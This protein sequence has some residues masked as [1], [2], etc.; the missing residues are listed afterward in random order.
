MSGK[1]HSPQILE[2]LKGFSTCTIANAIEYLNVRLRNVGFGDSS[3]H[4]RFPHF[5]PAVGYAVTLRLHGA[6][7]PMEG[8]FYVERTDWWDDL[9]ETPA[10][11]IVVIEDA[12]HRVGI[13]AF[14]GEIHAAILQAM[15][16][17]AVITNGSVR[18][19]EQVSALGFQLFSGNVS[20]SHAYAHVAKVDTPVRVAGLNIAP[21]D[22]LHGDQHGIVKIPR[23]NVERIL[24]IADQLRSR[25]SEILRFCQSDHFSREGLRNLLR[26]I[27]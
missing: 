10:P 7:P 9:A 17:V 6:N 26:H 8:G 14:V 3:V 23:G 15:G 11:H 22:L 25:E 27:A 16:C 1:P 21:G 4:C 12:D 18:D 24:E 19:L 2:R 5:P 20:V 13:A